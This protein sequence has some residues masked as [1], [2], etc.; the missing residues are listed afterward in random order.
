MIPKSNIWRDHRR[1]R[2][3]IC[4]LS[5]WREEEEKNGGP[6]CPGA[7]I[8]FPAVTFL[9]GRLQPWAAHWLVMADGARTVACTCWL[10]FGTT[11]WLVSFSAG[12]TCP[13]RPPSPQ[14]PAA[15]T[16]KLAKP[17]PRKPIEVKFASYL[18]VSKNDWWKVAEGHFWHI[19]N[20]TQN[21]KIKFYAPLDNFYIIFP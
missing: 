14:Q 13:P 7:A 10:S 3:A 19:V 5:P 2:D 20:S 18:F 17:R 1:C 9:T 16:A 21:H 15:T 11:S 8:S 4:A 6:R 12:R